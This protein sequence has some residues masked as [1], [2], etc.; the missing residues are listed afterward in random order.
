MIDAKQFMEALN[1]LEHQK[2]IAKEDIISAL[3]EALR[4]AYTKSLQGGDDALVEVE[5]TDE[6]INIKRFKNIVDEVNDDYIEIS[7]EDAEAVIAAQKKSKAKVK[8][9]SINKEKTLFIEEVPVE[10]LTRFMAMTV[11][12][13]LRQKLA[14]AEKVALYQAH[15]DKVGEMISGLVEKCDDY[16]AMVNIGRTT[17]FLS[18]KELIGDETFNPGDPIRM[19][20]ANVNSSNE[21]GPQIRVTRSDAGYLKKL[22]E[23]SVRDIYDGT[24][25]IKNIARD[26]GVRSKVAVYSNDPNVDPCSACIGVSGQTIQNILSNLGNAREKEKVDIIRYSTNDAMYIIDALKPATVEAIYVDKEDKSAIVIVPDGQLSLAIG[27]KG[28][29]ARVACHLTGYE[30]TIKE[31]REREETEDDLDIKFLTVDEVKEEESKRE[32]VEKYERY[33][34]QLKEARAKELEATEQISGIEKGK[35]MTIT[36]EDIKEEAPKAPAKEEVKVEVKEVPV[37]EEHVIKDEPRVV[38]TTTTL[39]SLEKSLEETKKKETF[40]ATKKTSKRPKTIT[41]EEV[42]HEDKVEETKQPL[43]QMDIYTKE[44]LEEMENEEIYED[45]EEEEDID[46]D[47][48]DKYYDDEQ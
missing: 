48:F 31:A 19:Y 8:P 36:D 6:Y 32:Q 2:G 45:Y 1:E 20:V 44:E 37:V 12:S 26:A 21:K 33:L 42:A 24:V 14:E 41:E 18:R 3:K 17:I 11:K 34:A 46:Y 40:K 23:E 27:R 16:G 15:K 39:E 9:F 25:I 5:I 30:I 13:V 10:Q 29:N 35:P 22:F 4:K 38:K 7:L 43:P 28:A 47:E